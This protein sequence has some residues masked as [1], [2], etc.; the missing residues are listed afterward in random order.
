[1]FRNIEPIRRVFKVLAEPENYP[2]FYHCRIGTERTGLVSVLV[3][4]LLGVPEEEIFQDYMLSNFGNIGGTRIV[5]NGNI[6]AIIPYVNTLRSY[7]GETF[8]DKV[9][10]FLAGVGVPTEQF[11]SVISLMS[12]GEEK[13]PSLGLVS[14]AEAKD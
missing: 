6:D 4:G 12:E 3:N 8:A 7:P 14:S 2:V 10:S 11:D 13:T 1:M 9:Y 5:N